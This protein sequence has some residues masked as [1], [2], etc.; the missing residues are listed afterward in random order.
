MIPMVNNGSR[1]IGLLEG[2]LASPVKGGPGH[3]TIAAAGK[4]WHDA[5]SA[6]QVFR[7]RRPA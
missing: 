3:G 7:F 6:C 4:T 1:L 5:L 2:R